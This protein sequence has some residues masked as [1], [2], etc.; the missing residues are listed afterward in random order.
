[1]VN[2][3]LNN[4]TYRQHMHIIL[5]IVHCF[6]EYWTTKK[7]LIVIKH[8]SRHGFHLLKGSV[9]IDKQD[10]PINFCCA[11]ASPE[12]SPR[13]LYVTI[14]S[15]TLNYVLFYFS[16]G[17]STFIFCPRSRALFFCFINQEMLSCVGVCVC[18]CVRLQSPMVCTKSAGLP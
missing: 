8:A 1:M 16:S 7:L 17:S 18:V 3:Y 10:L 11:Y 14:K 2:K 4:F 6:V 13:F 15:Y 5:Y 12:T 9:C